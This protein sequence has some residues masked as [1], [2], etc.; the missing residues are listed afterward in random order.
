M[1]VHECDA[2]APTMA[3]R[4][5]AIDARI[6]VIDGQL[7]EL[8]RLSVRLGDAV[9]ESQELFAADFNKRLTNL[10]RQVARLTDYTA[11]KH[12]GDTDHPD[13]EVDDD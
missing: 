10:A 1:D 2:M 9:R 3:D 8:T 11:A 6:E 5:K 4:L 12:P 7:T 13:F